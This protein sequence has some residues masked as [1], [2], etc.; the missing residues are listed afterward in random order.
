[1]N[2]HIQTT[3]PPRRTAKILQFPQPQ[4]RRLLVPREHGS[5][6]LWLLP[7]IT[8][9]VVGAATNPGPSDWAIFWFCAASA[10]AFL[11]YQ[12][13]EALLG[14]SPVK[15]RSAEEKQIAA[16]WVILTGFVA[17]ISAV[18]LVLSGRSRVL[19]FAL[20]AAA[21][22]GFRMLFTK[23]RALR[24]MRQVVGALA[25]SSA[26]AASYYVI[27]GRIDLTALVLWGANWVFAAGQIEYVQ[28]RMRSAGAHSRADKT[29]AGWKVYLFHAALVSITVTAAITGH[30]PI[31]FALLFI[32]AM[33][34]LLVWAMSR[35]AKIDFYLLGFSELFQSVLFSCLLVIAFIWR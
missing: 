35:P 18:E 13:L 28:L 29:R 12:P 3:T 15:A 26:A 6:G 9:A 20:L 14:I 1:M 17:L 23:V 4:T 19:F 2:P 10:A 22:F 32:P 24:A 11:A 31:F 21:C 16:T 30:A 5:W 27:S 34:R 33:V 8:G 7:L 25:L